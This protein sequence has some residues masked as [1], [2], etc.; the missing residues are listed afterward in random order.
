[1]VLFDGGWSHLDSCEQF[2]PIAFTGLW[3]PF[4]FKYE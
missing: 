2:E 4:Y 3:G 1:M